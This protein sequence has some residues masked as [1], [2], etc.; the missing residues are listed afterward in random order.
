MFIVTLHLPW[1][2]YLA[3]Q[4]GAQPQLYADNL[5]CVF[6]DLNLL[7]RAARFTTGYVQLVGQEPAPSTCILLSTSKVVRKDMRYW[8]VLSVHRRILS[9]LN[10]LV[11]PSRCSSMSPITKFLIALLLLLLSNI[12]IWVMHAELIEKL[13]RL[14]LSIFSF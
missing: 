11:N 10:F 8:P 4:E 1:C 2:P 6:G 5:K 12:F 7:L 9:S 14:S 13:L 3:A